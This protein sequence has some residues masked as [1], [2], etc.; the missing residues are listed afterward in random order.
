MHCFLQAV[1]IPFQGGFADLFQPPPAFA[2]GTLKRSQTI[3]PTTNWFPNLFVNCVSSPFRPPSLLQPH[4]HRY[5]IVAE[6][7]LPFK[8]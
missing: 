3:G 7:S 2:A 1:A 8:V 5:I 6:T 4:L